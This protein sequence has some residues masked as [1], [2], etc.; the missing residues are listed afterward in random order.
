MDRL[1]A[2]ASFVRVVE[3]GSFSGAARQLGVGQPAISKT[4]AQLEERLQVRLLL[5]STHGLTPTEAGLRFYERARLAIREADEAELEARGAGAGLSGRLRIS[6]AT[7]FA[8]LL[9]VPRLPEFLSRHPD[10]DMEVILDDRVIDLVSEGID[11]ALRMGTLSDST[12]VAR[13]IASGGRSVVATPAYLARAGVPRTP[14]DLADHDAVVYSQLSNGWAFR[15]GGTEASVVVRGRLRVSAAEGIRA[16]VLADLG[17]AVASDWMFG[18]ELADGSV[19]RVLEDWTLP[20]IDLW[21]V[22]PTGRLASTKA[23]AFAEFVAGIV[24]GDG[25]PV[26]DADLGGRQSQQDHSQEA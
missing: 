13:R 15:Q 21:A 6:A 5:R 4:I 2:M 3:T 26:E 18:P 23:R 8:R 7:T 19:R 16:A 10:L 22:F 1:Q 11:V 14:A 24:N 25:A 12:A 9:I 20:P 17:L